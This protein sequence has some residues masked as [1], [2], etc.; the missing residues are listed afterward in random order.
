M[1]TRIQW[2]LA[3]LLVG[4]QAVFAQQ[5][6][7]SGNAPSYTNRSLSDVPNAGAVRARIWAPR[8]DDGWV[9]QGVAFGDGALW[10]S[11]YQSTD[12]SVDSGPCRVFKVNIADGGMAGQFDLPAVCGHA[13]GLAH[14]GD[15][16]LYVA[17][18]N[19]LFRVDTQ[20]ALAAGKCVDLACSTLPLRGSLRGSFLAYGKRTLW[21]GETAAIG[22]AGRLWQIPE[23]RVLAIISGSGGTL[24][25]SSSEAVT[26]LAA[27][28]R[29]A[30]LTWDG[31]LW[32]TR[33]DARS[34]GLQK[35]EPGTGKV[36]QDY[37]MPAGVGDIDF[38]P[39]GTL[40]AVSKAG[41]M[42][43]NAWPTFYPLLFSLDLSSLH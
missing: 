9:P 29:G 25:E 11:A 26:P 13:G 19:Y 5:A 24:D 34:G 40:W 15:R 1:M 22:E 6:P 2:L 31:A 3:L 28:A 23:A 39:D 43:L 21:L 42:R 7:V 41:S 35:I 37:A 10:V 32:V 38:A 27:Q 16:Y 33:S 30:A 36:L 18:A 20:A 17:D 12:P 14:T 8:L 4:A